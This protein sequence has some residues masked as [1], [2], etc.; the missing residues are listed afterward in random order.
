MPYVHAH[1]QAASPPSRRT[2]EPTCPRSSRGHRDGRVRNGRAHVGG[3]ARPRVD[4]GRPADRVRERRR[5]HARTRSTTRR[6]TPSFEGARGR[7]AAASRHHPRRPDLAGEAR[8]R[9]RRSSSSRRRGLGRRR[10]ELRRAR[11]AT[12]APTGCCSTSEWGVVDVEDCIAAARH[13]AD[14]GEVDPKRLSIAGG[15][16]GGYTTLLALAL[17]DVFAAGTSAYGVTDLVT[18]RARRRTSSSRATWTG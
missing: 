6:R 9:P 18:L 1:G 5:P 7:A 3:R 2:T 17:S 16:A 13:L 4:L 12:A 8:L 10:R 11:P 15:S 14:A